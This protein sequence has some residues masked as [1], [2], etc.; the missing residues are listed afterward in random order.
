MSKFDLSIKFTSKNE[1]LTLNA[2]CSIEV[3]KQV[4]PEPLGH[5]GLV[6]NFTVPIVI[7]RIKQIVLIYH[8]I[9]YLSAF[10]M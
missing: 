6:T 8:L 7:K 9:D 2:V 1:N 3:N 5:E 4:N 10:F